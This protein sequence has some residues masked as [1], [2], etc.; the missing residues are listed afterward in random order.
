MTDQ[1][2]AVAKKNII[3]L[4]VTLMITMLLASLS[5]MVFSSALPTIVGELNGVEHM[6]W[7]ITAY[8]LASTIMMPIYGKMSD[9]LGRKPLLITAI[10]LFIGGSIFGAMASSMGWLIVARVIQGLGG[11]GLMILSQT[12][13]ADVIPARQR[14]KYAG[15]MGGVFALSSVAGPLLGGWLTE[16]AGWRWAF[17]LNIP[18]GILALA[19]VI[20]LMKLPKKTLTERPQLD[21]TGMALLSVTTVA[22][23]LTTTWGGSMF[24]WNSWPII[25]LIAGAIIGGTLFVLNE[26]RAKEPIIP[27]G[28]FREKNFVMV[29]IASVLISVAMFG[30]IGYMPTYFQ[31]AVGASASVAGLYMA[32]MMGALLL[33]SITSGALISK[34][35]KYKFFPVAGS[36]VLA[37][38]LGLLAT[39]TADTAVALICTYMAII[40]VGLGA[41]LQVLTLIVQNTFVHRVVG[42]ATAANNYFRQVGGSLGTAIV[43]SIF[44]T[45]LTQLLIERFPNGMGGST[46][47]ESL[48]PAL[49]ASLPD[50]LRL[51]IIEAYNGALIPIFAYL[52]P[53]AVAGCVILLFITEKP[54]AEKVEHDIPAESLAEGQLVLDDP[55]EDTP[56]QRTTRTQGAVS[57]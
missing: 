1:E 17:L 24:A 9:L 54:L 40:G 16:G 44:A 45:H 3:L 7:V 11:G 46:T 21:Y 37:L 38:G 27:M 4:F 6:T 39:V 32:P 28:L 56:S 23:I 26:R 43:G 31:M 8:M 35:G 42:T 51:P 50:A 12:A 57:S 5:Q 41:S 20:A 2:K 15:I 14:G 13:V 48:T 36:A 55:R 34:T 25:G 29:T 47:I 52:V 22:L 18:L 53:L 49:L 10:L 33:T 30:V 19:A